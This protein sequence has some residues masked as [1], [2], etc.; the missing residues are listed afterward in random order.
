VSSQLNVAYLYLFNT[1]LFDYIP[2]GVMS[3]FYDNGTNTAYF[4]FPGYANGRLPGGDYEA[5]IS[6]SLPDFY[7]NPLGVETLFTFTVAPPLAGDYDLDNVVGTAD[8]DLWK[9]SFG[10]AVAT[11]GS[12][13]DGNSDGV[14]NA[15]DYVVWRNNFGATRAAGAAA[16]AAVSTVDAAETPSEISAP[17]ERRAAAL[18]VSS[19]SRERSQSLPV[20]I[21]ASTASARLRDDALLAWLSASADAD[22][23]RLDDEMGQLANRTGG[24]GGTR[25]DDGFV[26]G[27]LLASDDLLEHVDAVFEAVGCPE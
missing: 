11:A 27:P 14:V 10:S 26:D 21:A 19:D 5:A 12:A 6:G 13:A 3:L 25:A 17:P 8:Y 4:T 20:R 7:G 23:G 16:I 1:T 15:A 2:F 18:P 22:R 24:T 9:A